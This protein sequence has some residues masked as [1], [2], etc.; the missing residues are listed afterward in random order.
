MR[1]VGPGLDQLDV[2]I[3]EEP[4]E[5]LGE[6]KRPRVLVSLERRGALPG[7]RREPAEHGQVQRIRYRWS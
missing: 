3:A 6:V 2:V 7:H 1:A 4:E 5:L